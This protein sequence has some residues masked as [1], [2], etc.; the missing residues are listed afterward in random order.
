MIL[1][2]SLQQKS[3]RALFAGA[4]AGRLGNCADADAQALVGLR[5]KS[6]EARTPY[7]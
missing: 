4:A 6:A 7:K 5:A 2:E 1:T 3:G